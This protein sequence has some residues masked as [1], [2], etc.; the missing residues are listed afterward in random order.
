MEITWN[1]KV[2][3]QFPYRTAFVRKW[4]LKIERTHETIAG[5]ETELAKA[6]MSHVDNHTAYQLQAADGTVFYIGCSDS[7]YYVGLT[8]DA[9]SW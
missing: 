6:V 3:K 5:F 2:L 4:F 8:I 1:T 7:S 9:R